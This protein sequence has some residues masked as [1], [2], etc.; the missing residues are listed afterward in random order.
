MLKVASGTDA[1]NTSPARFVIVE[2]WFEDVK[3]LVPAN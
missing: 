3:R 2:N 1:A